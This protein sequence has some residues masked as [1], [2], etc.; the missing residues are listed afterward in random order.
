MLHVIIPIFLGLIL[1]ILASKNTQFMLIGF[2]MAAP[3]LLCGGG[4]IS[5]G[6]FLMSLMIGAVIGSN[7]F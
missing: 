2:I 1:G 6:A 5:V 4:I 3:I 7:L